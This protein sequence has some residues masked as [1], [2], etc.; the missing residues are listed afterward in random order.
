MGWS[1]RQFVQSAFEEIGL[2][3]YVFDLS[4]EDLNSAVNRLDAMC[5]SWNARGIRLGYPIPASPTY[6]DLDAS[7]DVPDA[8]NEAIY[9][10]LGIRIAPLYGKAISAETRTAAKLA[11][12]AM[13]SNMVSIIPRQLGTIPAGAGNKYVLT[14]FIQQNDDPL[15]NNA[16]SLLLDDGNIILDGE[17]Y[18]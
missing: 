7:T 16:D 18:S 11:Y 6:A 9:T 2:A 15:T 8:A 1:K 5:A 4:P 12:D 13:M 14:R 17:D 10:N 3:S